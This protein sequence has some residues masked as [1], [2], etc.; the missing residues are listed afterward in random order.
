M[1]ESR[2]K[3]MSSSVRLVNWSASGNQA[4]KLRCVTNGKKKNTGSVR[5]TISADHR[6]SKLSSS[7]KMAVAVWS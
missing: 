1:R 2:K 4:D 6:V 5:A 3:F 7:R